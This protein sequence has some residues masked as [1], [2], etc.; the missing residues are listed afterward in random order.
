[1]DSEPPAGYFS[2]FS[3]LDPNNAAEGQTRA[4]K[5]NRRVFVCLP[6]HKRKLRCDKKQP[7]SRCASSGA[8]ED[9]I[10]QPF[11]SVSAPDTPPPTVTTRAPRER[12][13]VSPK[14]SSR[15]QSKSWYRSSNGTTKVTGPTHWACVASEVRSCQFEHKTP[16]LL[17]YLPPKV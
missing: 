9:C 6:C 11:P 14:L 15:Q 4:Q 2:T 10:Y 8:P 5:R 13:R 12:T 16:R 1:M 7:C 3:I 17:T